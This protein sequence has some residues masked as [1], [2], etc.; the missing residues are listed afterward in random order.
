VIDGSTNK[1]IDTIKVGSN[2]LEDEFN[3]DNGYIYV[4]NEGSSSVSVID[5]STNKVIDTIT[6]VPDPIQ[7]GYNPSNRYMYAAGHNDSYKKQNRSI[8]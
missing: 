4:A 2:P 6:G 3:P 5:G 8:V 1:V 7:L